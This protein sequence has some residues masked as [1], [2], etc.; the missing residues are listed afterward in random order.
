MSTASTSPI[1]RESRESLARLAAEARAESLPLWA[2]RARWNELRGKL[3]AAGGP[4]EPAGYLIDCLDAADWSSDAP[5]WGA[6]RVRCLLVLLARVCSPTAPGPRVS[7]IVHAADELAAARAFEDRAS[8]FEV[9][10]AGAGEVGAARNKALADARGEFVLFLDRGQRLDPETIAAMVAAVLHSPSVKAVVRTGQDRALDRLRTDDA[11]LALTA[12]PPPRVSGVLFPR[13]LLEQSGGFVDGP[14]SAVDGR[15][16]IRMALARA[17]RLRVASVDIPV[18]DR[19]PHD[20]TPEEGLAHIDADLASARELAA[21]PRRWRYV[22]NLLARCGGRWAAGARDGWP[23]DLL[24]EAHERILAAES[25]LADAAP[26]SAKPLFVDL[27][28]FAL[29]EQSAASSDGFSID[30]GSFKEREQ[31]LL[32]RLADLAPPNGADL[33]RWLPDLPPQPFDRLDRQDCS[34][35]KF[36]L[37]QLQVSVLLGEMATPFRLLVRV[38]ADYPG[39]PYEH[40][41]NAAERLASVVGD[42]PAREVCRRRM[43]RRGWQL[44]GRA[45]RALTSAD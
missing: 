36:A 31:N 5:A 15:H 25:E 44:L 1:D 26:P 33:R 23:A 18:E 24:E 27:L 21:S 43:F 40:Y 13:W 32:A 45:K 42:G 16:W 4:V 6:A 39:H 9:L 29:R 17:G 7:L 8:E 20:L 2:L 41:W 14:A 28:L 12:E 37:E 22:V 3:P 35:L 19:A 38:G 30:G 10:R 34:A 11:L